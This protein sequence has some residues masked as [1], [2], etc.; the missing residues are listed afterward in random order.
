MVNERALMEAFQNIKKEFQSIR[1][2]I[3][4]INSKLNL[5]NGHSHESHD[6][7]EAPSPDLASIREQLE[8][9]NSTEDDIIESLEREIKAHQTTEKKPEA[10]SRKSIVKEVEE[11]I[12]DVNIDTED[13]AEDYY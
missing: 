11:F 6:Y 3:E 2:D 5:A 10:K 13:I 1:Q 9:L 12:G 4:D 8:K 7:N